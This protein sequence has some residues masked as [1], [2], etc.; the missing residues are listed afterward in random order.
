MNGKN[1]V[2]F[3]EYSLRVVFMAIFILLTTVGSLL[4]ILAIFNIRRYRRASHGL[5]LN[6]FFSDALVGL[7]V[8]PVYMINLIANEIL[9]NVPLCYF[10]ALLTTCMMLF[11]LYSLALLC[12]ERFLMFKFPITHRKMFSSS[13]WPFVL[14]VLA[15]S[16]SIPVLAVAT[17]E[18]VYFPKQH[19]CWF[20]L[21]ELS[22][23]VVFLIILFGVPALTMVFSTLAIIK[24][25]K[26]QKRVESTHLP[27]GESNSTQSNTSTSARYLKSKK[28]R[29]S[30]LVIVLMVLTFLFCY[31][32]NMIIC[33]C[34]LSN[35]F[36]VSERLVVAS[37]FLHFS[38][39]ILNT[40][41]YGL[42]N[43]EVLHNIYVI[44]QRKFR[45]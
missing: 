11:S 4:V 24:T 12:I 33:F 41:I 34:E 42:L 9:N 13:V 22:F 21:K 31:A 18:V 1:M 6:L 15:L 43:R 27:G 20:N 14:I 2:S 19:L 5:L 38:K 25:I 29:R 28:Y 7:T 16:L 26:D 37:K 17:F 39:N 36:H 10:A 32:P 45:N 3:W 40:V 44:F 8:M 30:S 23:V 35:H